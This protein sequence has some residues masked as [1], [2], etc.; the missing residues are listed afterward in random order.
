MKQQAETRKN[1][2]PQFNRRVVTNK[3][4]KMEVLNTSFMFF[5]IITGPKSLGTPIQVHANRTTT[6]KGRVAYELLEELDP[7]KC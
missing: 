2:I 3:A 5:N 6:S 4:E 7:Y 1:T